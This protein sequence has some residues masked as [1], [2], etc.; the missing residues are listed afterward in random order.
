MR[1]ADRRYAG[2]SFL[3]WLPVGLTM[4]PMVLLL[5][6]R[7]LTLAEVA[8]LG[9]VSSVT[10]ALAELPTGGLAD[11]LGRRP[12]LVASALVHAGGLVLLALAGRLDLLVVSAVLRGLARAL[13]S[14]PL[15]AWYVDTARAAGA[16]ADGALTRGLARGQVASSLGIGA[17]TVLGGLLPFV[18]PVDP[19]TGLAVPILVA[20]GAEVLRGVLS[21]GLT[22]VRR[23]G[24]VRAAVAGVWP[25]VR[26]GARLARTDAVLLRLL[27]AGAAT[28]VALA[29]VELVTPAWLGELAADPTRAALLYAALVAS[30]FGADALGAAGSVRLRDRLGSSWRAAAASVGLATVAAGLLVVA[31][32]VSGAGGLVLAAAAYLLVFAGLG[33]AG[34]LLSELLHGRVDDESRATVLSVESLLFQGAGALGALGAGLLVT[35]YGAPAGLG[36]GVVAL[37]AAVG[38]LVLRGRDQPAPGRFTQAANCR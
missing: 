33:A 12:V 6:E 8:L 19:T 31:A 32:V 24:R 25:A 26:A 11:S 9:V 27:G 34:P 2:L 38:V 15:E 17:G 30:G 7:G 16:V 21:L 35:V 23:P 37:A 20:A 22:D 4:V 13:A 10:V 28:G 36:V 29:V 5:L 1:G 14:G 18:V 3:Q